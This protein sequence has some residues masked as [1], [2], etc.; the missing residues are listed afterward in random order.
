MLAR[1]QRCITLS[2]LLAATGWLLYFGRAEPV[3]AGAGFF[4]IALGYSAFLALEFM[5][6]RQFNRGDPAPQPG[7]LELL[8]AWLGETLTT[9]KIFYWWL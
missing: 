1:L 6:L 3:L 4:V 5:L 7:K 9:P 2:L 8:R